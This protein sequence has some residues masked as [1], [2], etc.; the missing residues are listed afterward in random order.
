MG[1]DIFAA[2]TAGDTGKVKELMAQNANVAHVRNQAGVSA[3]MQARY[4]NQ[5]GHRC[6]VAKGG[7]P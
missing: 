7:R 1:Q 2:I 5:I 3:L 4:E 6:A